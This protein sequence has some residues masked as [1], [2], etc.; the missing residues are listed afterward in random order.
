MALKISVAP[1][2]EPVSLTEAAAH[3]RIDPD[4]FSDQVTSAQSIAPGSHVI[5]AAYSLKGTGVNVAGKEAVVTLVSGK[6]LTNGTVNV[7]IQESD[8][9]SDAA[10]TD[11]ATGAFTQVTT[12]NDKSTYEKAYTGTKTYIRAVA[13]VANA[14]CDFGVNV[15]TN[16][17]TISD[18]TLIESYIKAARE[19]CEAFQNRTYITTTW[20]LWLD[21]FPSK[22][23]IEIPLPPL[24]SISS[25]KYYDTANV[26]AT[27]SAS[28]YF[29]DTKNEPGRVCLGY[30]KTWPST[31]LRSYNGVCVT[32]VA[33][34]TTA[35]AVSQKV[36][37]AMLLLIGHWYSNRETVNI[38]NI[39]SKLD[40]TVE[41]LLWSERVL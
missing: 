10:Y 13:T 15:L 32:F 24:S 17:P 25:V 20:E 33:G 26:E 30:G 3:L 1:T 31:T 41:A 6:N 4:G 28:D 19:Y 5:A 11:W 12:D 39:T 27:M 22:D 23:Y 2:I 35:A 37:Q 34:E 8:T 40:F 14:T 9:N 7:K 16:E 18:S 38:G 29:T 36:K 21:A